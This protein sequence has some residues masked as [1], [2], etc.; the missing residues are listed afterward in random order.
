[1]SAFADTS[2]RIA[3]YR[4]LERRNRFVGVLRWA[5]P[6][7]GLVALGV[8]IVQITISNMSARFSPQSISVTPESVTIE[9]PEYAGVLEDGARY[10]VSA[11]SAVT[12]TQ[13]P[14]LIGLTDGALVVNR[15]NGVTMH[16]NAPAAQL[17][18]VDELVLI[19]G[20][21]NVEDS[22]G[23]TGTLYNSVFD[24]AEQ[25]LTSD[26]PVEVNYAD[27]THL[28]AGGLTYDTRTAVWTFSRVTVTLPDT[29]GADQP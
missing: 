12:Y 15:A 19:E 1:M 2:E 10:H 3:T 17:Q 25:T 23:T 8:L 29:P 13:T 7:A 24:W 20:V 21:A 6:A 18:T 11:R 26:G 27:G 14:D 4:A 22:T 16:I 5:V 28:V 9:A